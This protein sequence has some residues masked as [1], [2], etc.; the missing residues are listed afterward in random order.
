MIDYVYEAGERYTFQN[1]NE[2]PKAL[3]SVLFLTDTPS[4]V[5]PL[6]NTTLGTYNKNE[7]SP[8]PSIM[9]APKYQGLQ[10]TT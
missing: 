8:S 10:V 9:C 2:F 7:S 5:G 3:V 1:K 4:V 6:R